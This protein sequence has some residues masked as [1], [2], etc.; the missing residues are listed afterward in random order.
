MQMRK[1]TSRLIL[2]VQALPN[3]QRLFC[4][5]I[6]PFLA[7]LA[8]IVAIGLAGAPAVA[9]DGGKPADRP[10]TSTAASP[11]VPGFEKE[12]IRQLYCED[13]PIAP[14]EFQ[15]MR[16]AGF[17]LASIIHWKVYEP[18]K[19]ETARA[20]IAAARQA[21]LKVMVTFWPGTALAP[22][23]FAA[24]HAFEFAN[25]AR[26][27]D[28]QAGRVYSPDRTTL[29]VDIYDAEYWDKHLIPRCLDYVRMSGEGTV[30]GCAFDL[31]LCD[32]DEVMLQRLDVRSMP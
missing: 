16:E 27:K 31:E 25:G 30:V 11:A 24:E 13:G 19:G 8:V 12:P 10:T 20:N 28:A 23:D 29:P 3:T 6:K 7:C 2:R 5:S 17:N 15:R 1:L 21:G 9:D 32:V 4:A 18:A 22:P 14:A 26:P